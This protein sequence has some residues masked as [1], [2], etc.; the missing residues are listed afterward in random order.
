VSGLFLFNPDRVLRAMP[1]PSAQLTVVKADEM[2]VG[3]CLQDK[4]LQTSVT[5]VTPVSAEAL[6]SLYNLIKQDVYTFNE[7]SVQCLQRHV[8]KLANAV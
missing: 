2:K 4:V 5:S 6:T 1:K 8:Q 3:S 7:T